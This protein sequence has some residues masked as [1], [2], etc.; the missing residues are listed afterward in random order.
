MKL[1]KNKP[2]TVQ[3]E[4]KEIIRPEYRK[5]V[6]VR[7]KEKKEEGWGKVI[8]SRSFL[9][10]NSD[11]EDIPLLKNQVKKERKV[12]DGRSKSPKVEGKKK[13]QLGTASSISR[14]YQTQTDVSF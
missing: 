10:S 12:P 9:S 5:Q 11:A 4:L 14:N 3:L 6:E 1:E 13:I 2:K 7:A 8:G